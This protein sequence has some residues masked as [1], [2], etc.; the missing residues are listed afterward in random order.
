[1]IRR[2]YGKTMDRYDANY[3]NR[4]WQ[5]WQWRDHRTSKLWKLRSPK[6]EQNAVA[7]VGVSWWNGMGPTIP[8]S[9]D[10]RQCHV[11]TRR[12]PPV[13]ITPIIRSKLHEHDDRY[14]TITQWRRANT[15]QSLAIN[16][17]KIDIRTLADRVSK[18]ESMKGMNYDQVVALIKQTIVDIGDPDLA[19]IE[20]R[21]DAI[22]KK[23]DNLPQ[24]PQ[25]DP[26]GISHLVLVA[27]EK[28]SYW[29]R[30]SDE[31][32]RAR[33]HYSSIKLFPPP[34]NVSEPMPQLIAY[35]GGVA[36][37]RTSG[38]RNVSDALNAIARDEFEPEGGI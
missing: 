29:N 21:L 12:L 18:F 1:M 31:L 32:E 11:I 33:D 2:T 28:A 17:N 26:D 15:S 14:P 6:G 5:D 36:V 9:T 38:V 16:Q 10:C 34:T 24:P 19:P 35:K 27:D 13:K 3:K 30:M 8:A 20:R 22:E 23:L 7:P 25:E 37:W 4:G